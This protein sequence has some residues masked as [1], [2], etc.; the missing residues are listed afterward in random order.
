MRLGEFQML[1]FHARNIIGVQ[2]VSDIQ[3]LE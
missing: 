3:V 2:V 1:T